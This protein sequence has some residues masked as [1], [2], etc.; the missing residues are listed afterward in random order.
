VRLTTDP[1]LKTPPPASERSDGGKDVMDLEWDEATGSYGVAPRQR[2]CS[3]CGRRFHVEH[4]W[5]VEDR[6]P[7]VSYLCSATCRDRGETAGDLRPRCDA[8]RARFRMTAAWQVVVGAAGRR[9]A[10]SL[11]CRALAAAAMRRTPR[12]ARRIAVWSPKGGSGKTTT[13]V[14]LAAALAARGQSVLLL[15]LDPQGACG[16]GLGARPDRGISEAILQRLDPLSLVTPAR[17]GLDLI[18]AGDAV[19]AAEERMRASPARDAAIREA[20]AGGVGHDLVLVDCPTVPGP[21]A[22]FALG[23]VEGV[24]VPTA[25]DYLSIAALRRLPCGSTD[26]RRPLPVRAVVPTAFDP[27]E[28]LARDALAVLRTQLGP[29]VTEPVHLDA[30][31]REA[32]A[33]G[34]TAF[35][36]APDGVAARDYAGLAAT[37]I[38]SVEAG[39]ARAA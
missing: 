7:F 36:H 15:D 35:E 20:L 3:S 32:P 23:E 2:S 22:R 37:L 30:A 13:A 21:L 4:R 16:L 17:P 12:P 9:Y 29:L 8:C 5:Q 14:H 18:A 19:A 1:T 11:E 6:G 10:C 26:E 28:P 31:L 34:Q 33:V 39:A 27:R 24:V 25:C 38:V